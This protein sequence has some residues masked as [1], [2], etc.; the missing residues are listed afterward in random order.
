MLFSEC[1]KVSSKTPR[2]KQ[3]ATRKDKRS[4]PGRTKIYR[5]R[6]LENSNGSVKLGKKEGY[7]T[8][9]E[10]INLSNFSDLDPSGLSF[11]EIKEFSRDF[12]GD[13]SDLV[14]QKIINDASEKGKLKKIKISN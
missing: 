13:K 10:I 1:G 7:S 3:A 9:A 8:S 11:S 12:D 6:R 4:N 2:K 14:M 5:L